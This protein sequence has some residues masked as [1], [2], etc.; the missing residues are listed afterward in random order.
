[1]IATPFLIDQSDNI[2]RMVFRTEVKPA[3]LDAAT[4]LSGHVVLLGFGS[5]GQLVAQIL[6][7]TD[8][9]YV[10]VTD[11]TPLA[12]QVPRMDL[13]Q[14]QVITMLVLLL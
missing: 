11:D 3:Y 6:D 1:M 2:V 9:R 12:Y 5:F 7:R 8:I 13:Q 10:V 4:M 14:V